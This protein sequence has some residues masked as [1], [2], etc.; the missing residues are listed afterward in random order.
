MNRK[1]PIVTG[2]GRASSPLHAETMS[3]VRGGVQRTARP[4]RHE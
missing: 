2:V 4:T 1:A 3:W